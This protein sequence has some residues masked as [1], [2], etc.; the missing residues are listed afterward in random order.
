[1]DYMLEELRDTK[2]DN[3]I[4][5]E[6]FIEKLHKLDSHTT[7]LSLIDNR[8]EN[9][10]II[11]Q[12]LTN[13]QKWVYMSDGV[14]ILEFVLNLSKRYIYPNKTIAEEYHNK[15]R[16]ISTYLLNKICKL[17]DTTVAM[18]QTVDNGTHSVL[19]QDILKGMVYN[20]DVEEIFIL[21]TNP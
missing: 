18:I 8:Y 10:I 15:T 2:Y 1:M 14:Y 21:D 12:F 3:T 13:Q 11:E 7:I 20:G 17:N 6:A 16:C 5:S 9:R 4:A 19:K